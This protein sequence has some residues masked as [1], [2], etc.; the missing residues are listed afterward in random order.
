[1]K[2]IRRLDASA[3]KNSQGCT[4]KLFLSTI[5]GYSGNMIYNDIEY[6]S[7]FHIFKQT[8]KETENA[9]AAFQSGFSYFKHRM[10]DPL[11]QWRKK[12][13][14]LHHLGSTFH[15]YL[16]KFGE[17][18]EKDNFVSLKR[19]VDGKVR[20]E[21]TFEIPLYESD[22]FIIMLCGTIDDIGQFKDGCFAFGDE[23]TTSAY[24][25]A[26]YFYPYNLSCQLLTY[27]WAIDWH[28]K[29][30]RGM[31]ELEGKE[32]RGFINGVFLSPSKPTEFIRSEAF[33]F[34]DRMLQ[35]YERLLMRRVRDIADVVMSGQWP[36]REGIITD[37]CSGKF[38]DVCP[39][40]AACKMPDDDSMKM[41]L[42]THMNKREYNPLM[43]RKL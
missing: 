11:F 4:L 28:I 1:V 13:L 19:I 23:K 41:F 42:E 26:D 39:F 14:D 20:V 5:K 3:L 2:Q 33:K 15:G 38:K 18:H 32:I 29:H 31:M 24:S 10:A 6:G 37:A 40:F 25:A 16:E 34:N 27:R 21:Q 17:K 35:T 22:T 8:L 36:D 43:F 30:K 12:H 7:A 9:A